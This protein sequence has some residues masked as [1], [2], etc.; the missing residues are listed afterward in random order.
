MGRSAI[1]DSVSGQSS[2][3]FFIE[4]RLVWAV[5]VIAIGMSPTSGASVR[6]TL[7]MSDHSLSSEQ[8]IG[9]VGRVAGTVIAMV[10]ALINWYIVDGK[11][12]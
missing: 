8:V 12:A 4:K 5:V 11:T 7:V 3:M 2:Y 1:A 6:I 9:F 10:I